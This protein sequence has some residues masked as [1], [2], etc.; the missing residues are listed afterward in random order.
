MDLARHL[1]YF[2]VVA[3]ELHFGRAAELLGIAQPPLSQAIQRLERDLGVALFDRFPAARRAHRGRPR[4]RDGG[5]A[6]AR[7]EQRLRAL[8]RSIRDGDLGTLRAGVPPE[9][10]P[11]PPS[12]RC[13]AASPSGRPGLDVD[14]QERDQAEQ[15]DSSPRPASTSGWS[16]TRS[17]ADG[18][19]AAARWPGPA[20]R[21]AAP[22]VPAGPAAE[23]D[24]GRPRRARPGACSRATAPEW[25]DRDA[26]HLPRARVSRRAG[27]GTP[28]TRSS[29]SGW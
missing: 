23:L 20:G 25:Y 15:L 2:L 1:R 16:I 24:L 12:V 17:A 19:G 21:G 28:A 11:A 9:R 5:G 13:C 3:E 22:H 7:R 8:M 4:A 29:C 10:S 6:V 18:S 14:L 26:R 27:S